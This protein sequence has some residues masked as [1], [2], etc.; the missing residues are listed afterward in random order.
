MIV[1]PIEKMKV[2]ATQN[3]VNTQGTTG[4]GNLAV[5]DEG[6]GS[7]KAPKGKTNK[8]VTPAPAPAPATGTTTTL[9]P[10]LL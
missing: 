2:K 10:R 4:A 3:A 9:S 5:T 6:V 8:E 1:N 7:D